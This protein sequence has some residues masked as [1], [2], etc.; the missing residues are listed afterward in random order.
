MKEVRIYVQTEEKEIEKCIAVL[1]PVLVGLFNTED[2]VIT[3]DEVK[4]ENK[5]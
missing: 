1:D 5:F 4:D 3:I 2:I